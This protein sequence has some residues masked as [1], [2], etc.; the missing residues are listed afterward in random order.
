M[1]PRTFPST[2][3]SP[4]ATA[5]P[6]TVVSV[7]PKM[8]SNTLSSSRAV[9]ISHQDT[10]A[11]TTIKQP[12]AVTIIKTETIPKPSLTALDVLNETIVK[13]FDGS[14]TATEGD[15]TKQ[16][17]PITVPSEFP[18]NLIKSTNPH[19]TVNIK[20]NERVPLNMDI[21]P[22][23]GITVVSGVQTAPKH[24]ILHVGK[25]ANNGHE[26]Q[27][28]LSQAEIKP[29]NGTFSPNARLL[30]PLPPESVVVKCE[31]DFSIV[32]CKSSSDNKC[33]TTMHQA[34]SYTHLTL[35][36]NR[37]V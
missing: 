22:K 14:N 2:M 18:L 19:E 27:I 21:H 23:E 12:P 36:T 25:D 33:S 7:S 6:V 29:I 5:N 30:N 37:E 9:I 28:S 32:E 10:I 11:T 16:E 1:T 3:V 24:L 4:M 31:P 15:N 17:K 26:K 20:G 8:L 35:P 13:S 34:V